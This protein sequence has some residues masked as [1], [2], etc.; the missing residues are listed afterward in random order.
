MIS[1]NY[2]IASS[3]TLTALLAA[4]GSSVPLTAT[5]A[6][7]VSLQPSNTKVEVVHA[8][9]STGSL[10]IGNFQCDMGYRVDLANDAGGDV[11]LIWRGRSYPMAA[12]STT[13]GAVRFEDKSSG[14]VWI[15]IPAKSMLLNAKAGQQLANE[16][17]L[18][19][20]S[21]S[22]KTL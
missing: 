3:L 14:M 19:G 21:K 20:S 6:Q 10:L 1:F 16:C 8:P 18:A 5:S 15:Q 9:A 12:V 17:I 4:C 22:R 2:R 13:T 11:R 7:P